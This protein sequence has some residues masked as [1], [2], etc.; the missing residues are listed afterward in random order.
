MPQKV[1]AVL[2]LSAEHIVFCWNT[3]SQRKSLA[4]GKSALFMLLTVFKNSAAMGLYDL[5]FWHEWRY[6]DRLIVLFVNKNTLCMY[7]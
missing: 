7:V 6:F 5:A 2:L 4:S 1:R 3:E